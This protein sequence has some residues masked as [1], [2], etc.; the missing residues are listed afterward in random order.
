[1]KCVDGQTYT[2]FIIVKY[3][4]GVYRIKLYFKTVAYI[5]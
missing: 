2:C 3:Y 4:I 5:V 1:M